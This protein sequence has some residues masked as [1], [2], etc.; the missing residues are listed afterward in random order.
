MSHL[1][2]CPMSRCHPRHLQF[3]LSALV[4]ASGAAFS[5]TWTP[6]ES[7]SEVSKEPK[8]GWNFQLATTSLV[9]IAAQPAYSP[10]WCL[11][12]NTGQTWLSHL[13]CPGRAHM[14]A[15]LK[16]IHVYTHWPLSLKAGWVSSYLISTPPPV[17]KSLVH[18]RFSIGAQEKHYILV[19]MCEW[20]RKKCQHSKVCFFFPSDDQLTT[21]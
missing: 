19:W 5:H 20:I 18:P 6:S 8:V 15:A 3:A 9:S 12:L 10:L 21:G 11:R 4:S 7:L 13:S 14:P 17:P 2:V 16:C 1:C